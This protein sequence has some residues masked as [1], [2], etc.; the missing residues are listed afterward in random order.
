MRKWLDTDHL[1]LFVILVALTAPIL[2]YAV[3]FQQ[4]EPPLVA[5]GLVLDISPLT[6]VAFGISYE[7]AA[8]LGLREA[9]AARKRKLKTWW[10]PLAGSLGQMTL[11]TFIV[12]PVLVSE[13]RG[14]ALETLLSSWGCGLWAVTVAAAPLFCSLT[15]AL[16]LAVQKKEKAEPRAKAIIA[17]TETELQTAVQEALAVVRETR[18]ERQREPQRE[19]VIAEDTSLS[20]R[21]NGTDPR[22]C[23]W[24][25]RS[26]ATQNAL[27]AHARWCE[28][29][30]ER[31]ET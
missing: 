8:F 24:C 4:A 31:V 10:W 21:D 7:A 30:G 28:K 22:V 2:R 14:L 12:S 23:G 11:G 26:F 9:V 27:N 16:V 15:V 25:G 6:G 1:A 20:E 18:E 29:R 19:A 3:A 5:W 17:E 13:M